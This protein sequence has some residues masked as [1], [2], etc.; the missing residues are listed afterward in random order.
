MSRFGAGLSTDPDVV[1]A[2]EQAA[3]EAMAPLGSQRPDLVFA[4]VHTDDPDL[5][6]AVGT[7]VAELTGARHV[8]GCTAHGVI[9]GERAVEQSTAVSVWAAVLP[10]VTLRTFH[11]EVIRT[12]ESLAVVGMP[13]LGDDDRL[14]VLLADPYTFPADGF[15]EEANDSFPG[16][17]LVGGMGGGA[18]GAGSTRLLLDDRVVDRGAVGVLLSGPIR[19]RTVVSQG[20]RP[21][22]PAMVVTAV[23]GNALLELAGVPAL[24]K[25]EQLLSEL[26]P[27][28]QALASRGLQIG[29]VMDEYAEQHERGDFLVRG[30][31]GGDRERQAV[32]VGDLVAV[33]RTVRFQVR[34]ADAAAEDLHALLNEARAEPA[35]QLVDGALLFTCTGRGEHL[36]ASADHD[37]RALREHFEQ[38]PVAGFFANGEIGPVGGRNHLHGFT[39]SIVTF[40]PDT[41]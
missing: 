21:I 11:L 14:C 26:T 7:R 37:V 15:V 22:G 24:S 20:C 27:E 36:F 33:G 32:L 41:G 38:V 39:A 8:V 18:R 5:V 1:A 13:D 30:V 10:G 40:G 28:D 12:G 16:L 29:V 9:G 35:G 2:A 3:H 17:P 6:D 19:L 23:D 34:D 4:F 25:L 31:I